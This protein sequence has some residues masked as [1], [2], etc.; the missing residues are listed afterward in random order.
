M[1]IKSLLAGCIAVVTA[2]AGQAVEFVK[3]GGFEKVTLNGVATAGS[4]EF[5]SR[6]A[7]VAVTDWA[8]SGYNF[9]FAAG[10]ADTVGATGEYGNLQLWGPNNGS[11]NGLPAASPAGGNF[12]GAD[13]A[14]GVDA[15]SQT[16]NG[17]IP[18]QKATLTFSWGAAQQF[19]FDGTTT[20]QW[21]VTLGS[22][23]FSTAV[24]TN[25]SHG[26]SGWMLQTFVFTP[27]SNS[28][29]LSFLSIGTP[30]GVPPFAVLDGV[31]LQQGVVP[32]PATWALLITGFAMVGMASR[33]RRTGVVTA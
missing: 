31:S 17:L 1:H 7:T 28:A 12:V 13:G 33:R 29:L 20:E 27:T 4:Y 10:A 6:Y 2:A 8:T 16:I 18:N 32:E 19:G 22:E 26:F 21:Q 30:A 14:F 5:G 3:N 25:A 9:V 15:I 23:T 24:V 11:A